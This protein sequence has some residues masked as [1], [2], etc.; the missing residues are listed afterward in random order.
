MLL[1]SF[2]RALAPTTSSLRR[3]EGMSSKKL[4][5]CPPLDTFKYCQ[6]LLS[7]S[8]SDDA[9]M[10]NILDSVDKL[11]GNNSKESN[12]KDDSLSQSTKD[13]ARI[14]NWR[15]IEWNDGA[16]LKNTTSSLPYQPSP[17]EQKVIQGR[18]VHIKR[19]DVLRLYGSQISGNKARKM[20]AMNEIPIQ[21]FPKIV[22]S[23]GGPQSNSML[24]LAA[25]VNFK[26]REIHAA[27]HSA[28]D[29]S[30]DDNENNPYIRFVYYTKKLPRFLRNQPSGNLFRAKMLGMELVELSP[31]EYS[32]MFGS[33]WGVSSSPPVGLE[34]PD[35][36]SLWVPQGGA[37]GMA[38]QGTRVL[39]EEILSYWK[40][41][42]N[43]RPLSVCLPGGTCSTACLLHHQIRQ[44]MNDK[45]EYS[46][47]N[48][49]VVVVPC[50]GDD[51]YARRQMMALSSS[52]GEDP[53]NIPTVLRPAPDEY[54]GTAES[55]SSSA[56][57]SN[58][59]YFNFGAPDKGILDTYQLLKE[60]Y[61]L[62]LDLIYG[63]P[64]WAV[65]LRHW[66]TSVG[67]D[68]IFDPNNPIATNRE[69]MYVHS[70]GLEGINSQLMRYQYKGL[71]S[72]KDVQLPGRREK[73][74]KKNH[75]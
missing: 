48:V 64:A 33:D 53:D 52:I 12:N 42:G 39:A 59:R 1:A 49:E 13:S 27:S 70:G 62:V 24:A 56:A 60:E 9:M 63:A 54:S 61:G 55:S 45:S 47:L 20:L 41:N 36:D 51:A 10:D 8:S 11:I 75:Y 46:D 28:S 2:A 3:I 7:S 68:S 40:E 6:R 17:V 37:F 19:D 58:R 16:D 22:V 26:N 50:V 18:T 35:K 34:P 71:L 32:D 4:N 21:D 57:K 43:N 30:K 66:E 23:Y 5:Y 15:T 14:P 73:T 25:I 69:L 31:D 44:I 67:I 29:D 74:K 72:I 65:L 38:R